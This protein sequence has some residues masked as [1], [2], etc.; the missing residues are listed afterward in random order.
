[1]TVRRSL[2]QFPI[3]VRMRMARIAAKANQPIEACPKGMT[4]SAASSG[5][6]APPALPPTWNI[7]CASPFRPPEASCATREDSGWKTEE[8]QPISPTASRM[9]TK[10]GATERMSSPTSV[11]HIPVASE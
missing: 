10:P 2:Y 1:M 6:M 4:T 7:D 5:P 3:L 11:K 8:P 9:G